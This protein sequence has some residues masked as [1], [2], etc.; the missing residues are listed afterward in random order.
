MPALHYDQVV[1][2]NNLAVMVAALACADAGQRVLLATDGLVLGGHFAGIIAGGKLFDLGMVALDLKVSGEQLN[3][4]RYYDPAIRNHNAHF[5]SSIKAFLGSLIDIRRVNCPQVWLEGRRYPDYLLSNKLDVFR[6]DVLVQEI[7]S[8]PHGQSTHLHA[9]NKISDPSYRALSYASASVY[10][11]GA[12]IHNR[13]IEPVCQ[14][15]LGCS[16]ESISASFHRLGWLP[17]YYPE[18]L[19]EVIRGEACSLPEY[20]FWTTDQGCVAELVRFIARALESHSLVDIDRS[21]MLA[22]DS[23]QQTPRLRLE[24]GLT[25]DCQRLAAGLADRRL[26]ELTGVPVIR[27]LQRIDVRVVFLLIHRDSMPAFFP[28]LFIADEKVAAYRITDQDSMAGLDPQWHRV[29]VEF[30]Q[31]QFVKYYPDPVKADEAVLHE[32]LYL[33]VVSEVRSAHIVRTLV[34]PKALPLPSLDNLPY[35]D[36]PVFDLERLGHVELT[37]SLLGAALAS[38]NDQVIQGM[39]IAAR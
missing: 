17:L 13:Y 20:P 8:D 29:S 5:A 14:K 39:K 4:V 37:G 21:R 18:T 24:S 30:N 34:A 32:L 31:D 10:N 35:L 23:T 27:H 19:N 12:Y 9:S 33:S 15:I 36:Q 26:A 6:G 22:V 2:G 7:T 16:S 28:C 25:I 11:H 38:L 1:I 3:D